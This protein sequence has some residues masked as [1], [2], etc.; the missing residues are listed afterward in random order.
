MVDAGLLGAAIAELAANALSAIRTSGVRRDDRYF[1]VRCQEDAAGWGT[2]IT[3]EN[4]SRPVPASVRERI[5]EPFISGTGG[6]G[7]GLSFVAYAVVQLHKGSVKYE[8][9]GETASRFILRIPNQVE[10]AIS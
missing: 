7:L 5:F 2:M 3:I 1:L 8:P 6:T 10:E 4:S 9:I